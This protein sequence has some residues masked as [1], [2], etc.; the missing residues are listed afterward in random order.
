MCDIDPKTGVILGAR[1]TGVKIAK[2]VKLQEP[3]RHQVC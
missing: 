1:R 2:T 3:Q